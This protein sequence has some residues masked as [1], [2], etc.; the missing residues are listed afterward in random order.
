MSLCVIAKSDEA[1]RQGMRHDRW[2]VNN[3]ES[4]K[5]L[6]TSASTWGAPY[7]CHIWVGL[8]TSDSFKVGRAAMPLHHGW[9]HGVQHSVLHQAIIVTWH[10]VT[11]QAIGSALL[12]SLMPSETVI[13]AGPRV[14][15]LHQSHKINHKFIA[16]VQTLCNGRMKRN[17]NC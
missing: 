8:G 1:N 17:L 6:I 15:I 7:K 9:G 3:P 14:C 5:P 11:C 10:C 12:L 16:S 13:V 4:V 2:N